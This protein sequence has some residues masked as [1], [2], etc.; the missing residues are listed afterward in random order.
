MLKLLPDPFLGILL[1]TIALASLFPASG[2][3]AQV[4][5]VLA[6]AAVVVLFFMHGVRL[7][8]ENLVA[9]LGHWRLHLAILGCTFVLMPLLGTGLAAATGGLLPASLWTGV[10]FLCCLPSTVQSSIAMVSVAR[11]NVA[12]A[13]ASAAAS[14]LLGIVL[15]PAIAGLVAQAHGAGI[16]FSGVWKIVLQ[17]LLPFAVGHLLR[18]VLGD[19]AA[20]RKAILT[21]TD[22]MTIV[23]AVYS[24]FSAAVIAGIWREVPLG[25]LVVLVVLVAVLL[26]AIMGLARGLSRVLGFGPAD[27]AVVVF[28]GSQKSLVSGVP[29]AR[30]LF[31]GPEVGAAVLPLMIYH[32]MQLMVHA[33]LARRWSERHPGNGGDDE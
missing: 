12:A 1:A 28:C 14:N 4:I 17:L 22:R 29:M 5:S 33:W 23:L 9:A 16:N 2:Q 30:V 31:S 3:A 27:S 15:T 11:G 20:R 6:T 26:G 13:V 8:R 24:A 7:P 32:Q 25:T 21:Y 18:P 19:W 10:L